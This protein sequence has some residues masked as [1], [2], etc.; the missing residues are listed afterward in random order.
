MK[1]DLELRFTLLP[2]N[3]LYK[4]EGVAPLVYRKLF[5]LYKTSKYSW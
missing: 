1:I 4:T 5:L 3:E 2:Q